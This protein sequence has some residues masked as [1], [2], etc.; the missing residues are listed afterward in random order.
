M[1]GYIMSSGALG[2]VTASAPLE[3]ALPFL[4]WRGAFW[5]VAA[6]AAGVAALIFFSM[7]EKER[8][9]M[10]PAISSTRCAAWARF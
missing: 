8:A 2:A 6:L 4:G 1:T 7:P 3:A 9:V 10:K 5:L